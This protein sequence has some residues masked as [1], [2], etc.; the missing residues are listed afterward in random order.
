MKIAILGTKGIPNNYGG[1]EQFAEYISQRLIKKG[2]L[3]T[4]YN[5][6][7]HSFKDDHF[8]G[9]SIIRKYSPEKLI[10]GAANFIYDYLCLKDALM[11]DFD[12]IYEAGYHSV[13]YS[14]KWFDVKRLKHPVVITNMDGLEYNR[15]KWNSLTQNLIKKLEK[16]A[17]DESPYMI[18]DN[19]GIQDY[20]R[21]NFK[22][23]SFFIP[24]GADLVETFD[25]K[26]LIHRSLTKFGYFILVARFEQ[27]NN[28]ETALDG[29]RL[30]KSKLP[31]IV[32]G[33]HYTSYGKYLKR[34]YAGDDVKFVGGI[35]K[36][37]ELDA[38]RHYAM[39]YFHGHSVGG[40]NPS[41]LEAMS[42][43]CFIVAHDNIFNK[44]VLYES[45]LYFKD[46]DSARN[47]IEQLSQL[48]KD[49]Q[50]LFI[51]E[52]SQRIKYEYNW[53]KIVEQH[54]LLFEQLLKQSH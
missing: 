20:Y 24:Y 6:S 11:R 30:S 45:A 8:H 35:Y 5:P 2:H 47:V 33:N 42:S 41:L 53:N 28:I 15:S 40:T 16:I 13:A 38:L 54:E 9:V 27:E 44:K 34:K 37:D 26:Y 14:L 19:I 22:K 12:I 3:V 49:N 50:D 46:V 21:S 10:G 36:K 43:K 39:A 48:R 25:E 7:F 32:V 4:V 31:F 17:V 29:Y 1:Y 23:D 52:N 18:S 51:E